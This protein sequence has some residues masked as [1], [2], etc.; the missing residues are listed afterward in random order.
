MKKTINT[1][2]TLAIVASAAFGNN[3]L[4]R[5]KG[6]CK[7][8]TCSSRRGVDLEVQTRRLRAKHSQNTAIGELAVRLEGKAGKTQSAEAVR[9]FA[10]TDSVDSTDLEK[11]IERCLNDG[12]SD[13]LSND[14][15]QMLS[16][17]LTGA[18]Q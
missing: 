16:D 1:I 3:D 11:A 13:K 12:Q 7:V 18:N 17:V 10:F 6:F 2:L 8:R 9:F 14:E 15:I 4:V 5:N